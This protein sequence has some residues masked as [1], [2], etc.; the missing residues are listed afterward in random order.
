MPSKTISA[1]LAPL[2]RWPRKA[3]LKQATGFLAEA[4]IDSAWLD[5]E[6][7]LAFAIGTSRADVLTHDEKIITAAQARRFFALIKQRS[8]HT[9]LAYLTG[10]K[11][12][13]GLDF[14]V[15]KDT[16]VPRPESELMV[17][18]ALAA[19]DKQTVLI[20]IGTGS[21]CLIISTLKRSPIKPAEAI[22][23]D[24]SKK[25]LAV[26]KQN[27]R[28]HELS[29]RIAFKKSDLLSALSFNRKTPLLILANL[30]YLT[31]EQMKETSIKHEPK[32]ALAAGRD[33]L[34]YYRRLAKQLK[35]ILNYTLLCEI[36]P[37]QRNGFKKIFPTAVFKEDL[38]GKARLAIVRTT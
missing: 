18:E 12:F 31:P 38:S 21:G 16:L 20:D 26:A 13:Y 35:V 17:D 34:L 15:T 1:L 3:A 23:V 8:R 33:G 30:P 24:I 5:S 27:A 7:L 10:H 28:R 37:G 19:I 9:P 11:E 29:K 32:S 36:N 6:L 14:K 25:A 4:G 2:K 22:A